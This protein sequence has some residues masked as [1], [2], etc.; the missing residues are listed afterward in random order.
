MRNVQPS[1][2]HY[3]QEIK[4]KELGWDQFI[5]EIS[6][7]NQEEPQVIY[8]QHGKKKNFVYYAAGEKSEHQEIKK[9]IKRLQSLMAQGRG[10]AKKKKVKNLSKMRFYKCNKHSHFAANCPKKRAN[11]QDLSAESLGKDSQE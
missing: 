9:E 3:N 5:K 2:R 6:I 1:L 8:S 4:Q 7:L 11:K 10:L